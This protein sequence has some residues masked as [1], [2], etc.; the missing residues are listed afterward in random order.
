MTDG[1]GER[2]PQN[3]P[4]VFQQKTKDIWVVLALG[5]ALLAGGIWMT[6]DSATLISVF[7]LFHVTRAFIGWPVALLGAVIVLFAVNALARGL[8]RLELRAEGIVLRGRLGGVTRVCWDEVERVDV[9]H[10]ETMGAPNVAGAVTFDS[11]AIV[12]TDGRKVPISELGPADEMREA[13]MRRS[14]PH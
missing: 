4:I 11:V 8:P 9:Q 14:A 2:L 5:V 10:M 12:T 13:I 1:A 3:L 7:G 6:F